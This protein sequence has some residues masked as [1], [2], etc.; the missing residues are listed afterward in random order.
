MFRKQT[1]EVLASC[2]HQKIDPL[3]RLA[4]NIENTSCVDHSYADFLLSNRR[5]NMNPSPGET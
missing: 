5:L 4:L 1:A 2:V 3:P